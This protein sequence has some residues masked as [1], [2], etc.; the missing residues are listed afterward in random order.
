MCCFVVFGVTSRLLVINISSSSPTINR[1]LLAMCCV[2]TCGAVAVVHRQP[3][4]QHLAWCIINSR[5]WTSE[6]Q[7]LPT[8][9]AFDA[10][11]KGVPVGISP[12]RLVWKYQNGVDTR[13]WKILKICLFVLT[14][15]TNVTDRQTHWQTLHDG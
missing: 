7:F 11:V 12:P 9:P 5:Q 2:T 4:W 15:S 14:W 13:R 1:L 8:Q 6:S 3:C 10:P